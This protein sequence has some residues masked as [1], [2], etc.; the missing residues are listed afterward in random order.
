MPTGAP[1]AE[2]CLKNVALRHPAPRQRNAAVKNVP[3]R[4]L[5][6]QEICGISF[7]NML[8][9]RMGE[10]MAEKKI[11]QKGTLTYTTAGVVVLFCWL[12]WG[13]FA[14]GLKERAVGQ[15][16]GLMLKS[17]DISNLWYG[18]L[19]ISYPCFTNIFLIR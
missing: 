2:G 12:L 10:T 13:D 15:V 18:V 5:D 1:T 19:M 8:F 6:F 14:W 16:A 11:W 7:R 17:F 9:N 3:F 4:H